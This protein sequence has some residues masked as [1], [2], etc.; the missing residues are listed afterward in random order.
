MEIPTHRI[1][2]GRPLTV[3]G[4]AEHFDDKTA[5]DIP[6]LWQRFAPY[7]DRMSSEESELTYGVMFDR[8][9]DGFVY[10]AAVEVPSLELAPADLRALS[11][12]EATYAV[13]TH[14]GHI[15]MLRETMNAIF[16]TALPSA[17]LTLDASPAFERYDRR[18]DP[19]TGNGSSEI[20][21]PIVTRS[22]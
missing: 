20:W 2:R 1:E 4:L 10:M 11:I 6:L 5:A 16:T 19:R 7:I 15:S 17:R 21:F 8:G 18:F 3:A 12:P 14:R 22:G 13:F 9:E